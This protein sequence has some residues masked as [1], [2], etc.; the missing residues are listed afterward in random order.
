[1]KHT[2]A[3]TSTPIYAY[4]CELLP[5]CYLPLSASWLSRVF[6][7]LSYLYLAMALP[8]SHLKIFF[9]FPFFFCFCFFLGLHL[10]HM[11]ILRPGVKLDLQL[12]ACA[13]T[14]ARPDPSCICHLHHTSGEC[15]ILN[16]LSEARD[17][18]HILLDTSW[19]PNLLRH[20]GNSPT[21]P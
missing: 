3:H 7:W 20:N 13:T 10:R 17:W 5:H 8:Q 9:F 16:L 11:E 21:S 12:P 2:Q 15:Q 1:M 6:K 18:T 14:T 19:I 4:S